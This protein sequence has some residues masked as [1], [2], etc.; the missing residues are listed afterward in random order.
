MSNRQLDEERIFHVARDI[1]NP[2]TRSEYLSQICAGDQALR[3]RVEALLE[4]HEKEENF[5]QSGAAELPAT[6]D[7]AS[8][9]ERPGTTIGPFGHLIRLELAGNRRFAA[10]HHFRALDGSRNART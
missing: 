1:A 9:T 4:V 3:E 5:L 6:E 7:H 8:L 2:E 10:A